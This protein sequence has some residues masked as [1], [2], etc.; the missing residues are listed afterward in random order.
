MATRRRPLTAPIVNPKQPLFLPAGSV[1]A[2]I[3]LLL[4]IVLCF[5]AV[6]KAITGEAFLTIASA[7]V[8]FYFGTKQNTGT[9]A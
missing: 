3:A 5:M 4:V 2:I 7:V 6:T 8:A 1:R 9:A